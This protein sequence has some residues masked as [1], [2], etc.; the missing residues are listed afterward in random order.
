MPNVTPRW[1]NAPTMLV[2]RTLAVARRALS[3]SEI[4][5][6]LKDDYMP[7]QR[8]KRL[9]NLYQTVSRM[10]DR[11]AVEKSRLDGC[12]RYTITTAGKAEL[13]YLREAA[14]VA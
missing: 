6:L 14:A 12:W 4:V 2:L 1:K 9:V 5:D 3:L 8:R 13:K 10:V 7:K 11:R